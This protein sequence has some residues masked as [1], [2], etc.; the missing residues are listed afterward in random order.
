MNQQ[1]L[2]NL[3]EAFS[4]ADTSISRNYGGTGS[5]CLL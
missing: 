5:G 1:A 4:Q 3:F 2:A